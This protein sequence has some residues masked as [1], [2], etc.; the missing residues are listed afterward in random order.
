MRKRTAS[1]TAHAHVDAHHAAQAARSAVIAKFTP[2]SVVAR[3]AQPS[4]TSWQP[5]KRRGPGR[6]RIGKGAKRVLVT[7]ERGLL[8]QAD[9]YARR[10]H[11]T[12][13]HL[14]CDALRAIMAEHKRPHTPSAA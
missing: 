2:A 5:T 4:P 11:L 6:P 13:S 12:R 1:T 3:S 10:H 9:A 7:V 8:E 14:I